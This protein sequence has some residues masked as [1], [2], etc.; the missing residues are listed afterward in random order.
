MKAVEAVLMFAFLVF[1]AS[2]LE[3]DLNPTIPVVQEPAYPNVD[4]AL[5]PH[6]EAFEKV[7]LEQGFQIDL[8]RIALHGN[9]SS[10]NEGN[11]VGTCSYGGRTNKRDVIIDESFWNRA[12]YLYREYVVFHELGHCILERDH[13]ES[14]F[15]NRTVASIMRSGNGSCR[16][17]YTA[18]TR[19]YYVEELFSTLSK[20]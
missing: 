14:C 9:I 1:F 11:V 8:S 3:E 19:D 5:W 6:F 10:I 17:N 7:A 12:S 4:E 20:P 16:D 15:S 13:L 2:C 18:T